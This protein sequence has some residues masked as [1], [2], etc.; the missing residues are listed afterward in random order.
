MNRYEMR[1]LLWQRSYYCIGPR[2]HLV[3]ILISAS[4]R[5]V[6][7]IFELHR[8][9]GLVLSSEQFENSLNKKTKAYQISCIKVYES[10]RI[11]L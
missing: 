2:L 1:Y 4:P 7:G 10:L 9:L 11:D 5:I 6:W 8:C 3:A